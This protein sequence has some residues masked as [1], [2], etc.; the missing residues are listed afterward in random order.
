MVSFRKKKTSTY[1]PKRI[2]ASQHILKYDNDNIYQIL[3]SSALK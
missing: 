1:I 2:K 3:R